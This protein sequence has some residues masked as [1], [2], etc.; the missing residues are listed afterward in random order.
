MSFKVLHFALVPLGG[1][2]RLEGTKV[3]AALRLRVELA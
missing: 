3:S 2:T 1:G